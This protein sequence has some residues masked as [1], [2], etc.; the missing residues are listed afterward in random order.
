MHNNTKYI[1]Q[2]TFQQMKAV[3]QRLNSF[4]RQFSGCTEV[5]A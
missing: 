2:I 3:T 1:E 4:D 5:I